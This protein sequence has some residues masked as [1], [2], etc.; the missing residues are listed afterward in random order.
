ME[1]LEVILDR[2]PLYVYP[3]NGAAAPAKE[4]EKYNNIHLVDAPKVEVASSQI[5]EWIKLGKNVRPLLPLE[6]WEYLDEM[7]FYKK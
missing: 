2:Y 3:R 1:N 4:L 5:R 7:N 6:S